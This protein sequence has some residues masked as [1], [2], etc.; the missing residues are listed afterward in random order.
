MKITPEDLKEALEHSWCRET[1]FDQENWTPENPAYS[2]CFVTMLIVKDY[3]GGSAIRAFTKT[4]THYWNLLL[5][6]TEVDLTRKQFANNVVFC[7]KAIINVSKEEEF[8]FSPDTARRYKLL[9]KRV[10][11]YLKNKGAKK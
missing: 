1:A 5:D 10:K 8:S 9:K 2:Q 3:F 4:G 6:G 7:K 11:E